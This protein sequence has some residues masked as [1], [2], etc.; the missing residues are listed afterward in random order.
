[1]KDIIRKNIENVIQQYWKP[2]N[3]L[4]DDIYNLLI[5]N[6]IFAHSV[7]CTG[8]LINIY[9]YVQIKNILFVYNKNSDINHA[10]F[11]KNYVK[12]PDI[13]FDNCLAVIKNFNI[14]LNRIPKVVL[15]N[16]CVIENFP[17]PRLNLSTG[18]IAAFIRFHQKARV[19]ILDMQL[20]ITIKDILETL[21]ASPPDIIG[22]SISFGQKN[23]SDQ[24]IEQIKSNENLANVMLIVGNVI[25]SL[26]YEEYLKI[27]PNVIV[28]YAEGEE[29]FIDLIDY[30]LGRI[31]I[32]NVHGIAYIAKNGDLEKNNIDLLDISNLPFPAL[33]T[34]EDV[35]KLKGAITLEL[36]RGCNYSRCS[37]CPRSHKGKI[38]RCLSVD[39]MVSYFTI[40]S[41]VCKKLDQN[42]FFYIAD[43][44]FIGQLPHE[45]EIQRMRNFC[46]RIKELSIDVRFDI[47]ARVDSIYKEDY[48]PEQNIER[49]QM[50]AMLKEIGL[51]RLFL[52][53]ESGCDNQ[54]KRFNKGTTSHQNALAIK[55][56]TAIGINIRIGYITFD[57]LMT[58]FDDIITGHLF[59]ERNDIL[60]QPSNLNL[61]SIEQI[62]E[63][64]VNNKS[65]PKVKLQNKP[66]YYKISYPLTSLEVLFST[67]YSIKMM[68]YQ[69]K[70]H[71][72]LLRGIDINMARYNSN[73]INKLIG[74]I[75]I[76]CQMWIDY[77][78]PVLYSLK[79][80]YK[81]SKEE[82]R[83]KIYE[84]MELSKAIDHYLLN[85]I[86]YQFA[87]LD[88]T[89]TLNV[90][91]QKYNIN[92][93]LFKGEYDDILVK[94]LNHW[95]NVELYF[96]EKIEYSL[97]VGI[98][99]DTDDIALITSIINW[100]KNRGNWYM[101]N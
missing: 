70:S 26:Y 100:K 23:L 13:I 97:K 73:Y 36:S 25:P 59:A 44:E 99:V 46:N 87:L 22:I 80:L 82:S 89:Y 96:I 56:I 14:D 31:P 37:F 16:M 47:S 28:S 6:H 66:L 65:N 1:M 50:W 95:Q 19:L 81:T 61:I 86:L 5:K 17:I 77:N 2:Y 11:L 90:F 33:D 40:L 9:V 72:M 69:E 27:H 29:S 49:L 85:F 98:I 62:Y 38:W 71:R 93:P 76:A 58:D 41:D 12:E 42:P 18:A 57:P 20:R 94:S 43:E 67:P 64:I 88:D 21:L 68:K 52:G 75:S 74:N 30:H 91:A 8:E 53:V 51:Q 15:I 101:I 45:K 54:L 34:L 48:T 78:F 7:F 92:I 3:E 60:Y 32:S 63:T 35:I 83:N 24:L 55:L 39:K 4:E 10:Y 84:L 79:G